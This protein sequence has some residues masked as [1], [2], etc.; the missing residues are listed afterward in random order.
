V[1]DFVT[2]DG[3]QLDRA[4]IQSAEKRDDGL[5]SMGRLGGKSV[6]GSF[7]SE[8][9]VGG[10]TSGYWAI[11]NWDIATRPRMTAANGIETA[12]GRTR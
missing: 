2:G 3:L 5:K 7:N 10:A 12:S 6:S 8:L 11:G 1:A 9:T 4:V